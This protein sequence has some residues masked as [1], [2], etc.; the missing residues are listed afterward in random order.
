MAALATCEVPTALRDSSVAKLDEVDALR[1]LAALVVAFLFHQHYLLGQ[2]RSGPLA[3]WPVFSW[4]HANGWVMVDLFFVISGFIFAHVY[5]IDGRMNCEPGKFF[6]ARFARLYPLHLVMLL[7][8]TLI[9]AAGTPASVDYAANDAKHFALNLLMLQESGLNDR[10]SFNLPSWSISVEVIC[11]AIFYSVASR[12]SRHIT[13]LS[14]AISV[15]GL[16]ATL[17]SD[18]SL[19]HIGRGACGFFAGVL[20]HRFRHASIL[21]IA[22]FCLLA[23]SAVNQIPDISQGAAMG[24]SLFPLLL[25]IAP[26]LGFLRHRALLWLGE[27]SYSIYLI[28]AP[29]Y[30][31]INVLIFNGQ[32]VPDRWIW[33][34]VLTSWLLLLL[35][36]DSSYRCLETPAR[37][38]INSPSPRKLANA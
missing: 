7:A 6:R 5:L 31:A 11:Y 32:V 38:W 20:A 22:G 3:S 24:I 2:F 12:C 14:A 18:P 34:A 19:D 9:A 1:G 37:K 28:H 26:R 15:A 16:L 36:S 8:A 30:M 17:G 21:Y 4:F 23:F 35:L 25:I 29:L 27:R 33:L 13:P 10:M